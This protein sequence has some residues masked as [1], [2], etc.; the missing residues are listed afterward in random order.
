M[1]KKI[2]I[3]IT[4]LITVIVIII[5]IVGFI[6]IN[7]NTNNKNNSIPSVKTGYINITVQN[8]YDLIY[9]QNKNITV[10]DVPTMGIT[11]YNESHLENAIMIDDQKYLPEGM[12]TLYNIINDILIYDDDG[13]GAGIFYCEKLVNHTDGKIYY[14]IGGF[15]EWKEQG[16]P[17]WSWDK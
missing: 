15:S 10:I 9:N 1:N 12:E 3:P 13:R 4:L 8:A 11:R 5:A 16:Y 17:F 6:V 2:I 7:Q 14:L